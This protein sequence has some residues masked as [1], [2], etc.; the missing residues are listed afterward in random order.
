MTAAVSLETIA[1]FTVAVA[2]PAR[3]APDRAKMMRDLRTRRGRKREYKPYK[4]RSELVG[5]VGKEY[6]R[7]HMRLWRAENRGK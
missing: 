6:H 4:G 3:L 5:L 2:P 1:R 7:E